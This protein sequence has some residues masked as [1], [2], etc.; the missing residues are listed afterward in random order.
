MQWS[1]PA[2]DGGAAIT[3]YVL[4]YGSE[5]I[6][7][8]AT[9]AATVGGLTAGEEYLFTL[10]AANSVG[11]GEV[12]TAG[13]SLSGSVSPPATVPG[14]PLSLTAVAV[15]GGAS[16][17]WV[18]P[19]NDGGASVTGYVLSY[20]TVSAVLGNTLAATV[21]GLTAGVEY[22]FT[23][24]A[25][26]SVGLGAAATAAAS[27]AVVPPATVPGAPQS[28]S[29]VAGDGLIGL[30]WDAPNSDGGASITVYIVYANSAA[31][32][33]A[34]GDASAA[35]LTG[36]TN[37][38]E[39]TLWVNARNSVG[40]SS[41]SN[42]TLATPQAAVSA[43]DAPAGFTAVAVEGGA[44]LQWSAPASDGGASVTGYI[45][46]Y[47][48]ETINLGATLA[49]TLGGLTP[50]AEYA[51]TLQAG[52]A[53]GLGAAATAAVAVPAVAPDA[54]EGFTASAVE[55]GA[56]L[57]WSAPASD[58]GA[59]I[60]GYVLSYGSETINLGATTAAT[61]GGL[62]AGEEYLFT[63][64][65]AN[66]VGLGAAAT[67]GVSLSGSVSPPA[68]V[69]GAPLSLT[70]VAVE[71]GASLSWAAPAND[72]GASVTGYVL[73]YGA[74][75]A[76]LGATPWRRRLAAW[77]RARNM[78][79]PCGRANAVGLGAAATAGVSLSGAVAPTATV[80]SRPVIRIFRTPAGVPPAQVTVNLERSLRMAAAP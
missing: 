33:T 48:S 35:T 56:S 36:L 24:R 61:V 13:V 60:T 12:A 17:S 32:L 39:Y 1:A 66:S 21:G 42:A 22:A 71:G 5:T 7:L 67:A 65:A 47:G 20:G 63:L 30:T 2:S 18:A 15:E 73:S 25:A 23:L 37:G 4:S 26:N 52:N 72:G 80:P 54:P 31:A 75:T 3:G 40:E 49:A 9:T 38:T 76:T 77:R 8:G 78:C 79:L 58:G 29:A 68:T 10:Q 50:G 6:N 46:T 74:E 45:L 28:L 16:L 53:V 11:L 51:F 44:S 55:G 27:L 64:Q 57:Q 62:T 59:T 41:Q 69:P 34:S 14:A 19:A 43:P 70:A